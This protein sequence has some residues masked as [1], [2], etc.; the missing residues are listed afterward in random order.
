[1]LKK[2]ELIAFMTKNAVG[3]VRSKMCCIL[4]TRFTELRIVPPAS[5]QKSDSFVN[6]DLCTH[7]FL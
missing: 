7:I 6:N 4:E 2:E 5:E 1:V 3:N